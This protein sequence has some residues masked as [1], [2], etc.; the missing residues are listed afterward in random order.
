VCSAD[1]ADFVL[2]KFT[3]GNP[4]LYHERIKPDKQKIGELIKNAQTCFQNLLTIPKLLAK[5][6]SRKAVM[7][8]HTASASVVNSESAIVKETLVEKWLVAIIPIACKHDS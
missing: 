7:P 8:D 2:V 4:N 6:Y 3:D 1:Y 5:W